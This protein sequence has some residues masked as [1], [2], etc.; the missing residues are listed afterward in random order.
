MSR[1]KGKDAENRPIVLDDRVIPSRDNDYHVDIEDVPI[2]LGIEESSSTVRKRVA[3]LN[4]VAHD[5]QPPGKNAA[6]KAKS[7]RNNVDGLSAKELFEAEGIVDEA[8][9]PEGE[10]DGDGE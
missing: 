6:N 1:P 5:L 2:Y 3:G 4:Q 10:E 7:N 9:A 8:A